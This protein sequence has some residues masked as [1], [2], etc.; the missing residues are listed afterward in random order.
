MPPACASSLPL[1][2]RWDSERH[3]LKERLACVK[4]K[5]ALT[6]RMGISG[7]LDDRFCSL[8]LC[9]VQI[10]GRWQDETLHACRRPKSARVRIGQSGALVQRTATV[11]SCIQMRLLA[12]PGNLI[13]RTNQLAPNSGPFHTPAHY[14]ADPDEEGI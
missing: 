12:S 5:C 11:I 10:F 8:C 3:Q 14:L 4:A 9:F 13:F 2:S 7:A 6:F 1:R